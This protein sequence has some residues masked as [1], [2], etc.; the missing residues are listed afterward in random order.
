MLT[1]VLDVMLQAMMHTSVQII[2][3]PADTVPLEIKV[4]HKIFTAPPQFM[5]VVG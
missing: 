2:A 3:H 5:V 1:A 4:A